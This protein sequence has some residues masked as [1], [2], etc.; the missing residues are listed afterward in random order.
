MS[1]LLLLLKEQTIKSEVFPAFTVGFVLVFVHCTAQHLD[2]NLQTF[3][4]KTY[5][6]ADYLC[7]FSNCVDGTGWPK[8]KISH[9]E[10]CFPGLF[11]LVIFG[12]LLN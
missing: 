6:M 9:L 8:R 7:L 3:L 5:N 10:F 4:G 2:F 12:D 1:S 11:S